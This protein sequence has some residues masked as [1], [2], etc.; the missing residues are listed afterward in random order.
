MK[1]L[2]ITFLA[3]SFLFISCGGEPNGTTTEEVI[4]DCPTENL[5][6][7]ADI[8]PIIETNC[9]PC[10]NSEDY[11]RKADGNLF[12]GY[13]DIKAKLDEGLLIGNIE[14]LPGFINMPYKKKK[15]GDC[16]IAKIKSWAKAGAL[17]N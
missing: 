10:H 5:S 12:A 6:F 8:W 17:D 1:T 13:A 15:I 14:H 7:K 3:A 9:L 11:A 4:A 16:E 2:N